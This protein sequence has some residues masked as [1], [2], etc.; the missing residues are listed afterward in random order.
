MLI[1]K[2]IAFIALAAAIAF[3]AAALAGPAAGSPLDNLYMIREGRP[4]RAS[5]SD[6]AWETGNND[7]R[8]LPANTDITIANLEGPG[9]ITH[10]WTTMAC[11]D[12]QCPRL[13]AIRAYWDGEEQPSV[14]APLGDFFAVGHGM[15]VA[16]NSMPVQVSSDGRARNSFW[17]MPFKKSAKI[18]ISNENLYSSG[19]VIYWYVDWVKLDKLP[20]NAAYFHAQYRQEFPAR[21][22]RYKLME[23][24]G[25]GQYVGTVYSV[26]ANMPGWIGEGDDFFY[27]D[28]EKTPS[29]RGTGTEDYFGDAWGF[30]WFNQP[31]H[32]VSVYEGERT[33]GRTTA[34]RWHIADPI[35]F[36]KSIK[37]EIEHVG[38]VFD[39]NDV[40]VAGYGERPDHYATVAFWYQ[41][42]GGPNFERMPK[43]TK[44]LPP[45]IYVEAE[46]RFYKEGAPMPK[47]VKIVSDMAWSGGAYVN[48]SPG[49]GAARFEIPIKIKHKNRYEMSADLARG[50]NMGVYSV[51]LDGKP[52]VMLSDLSDKNVGRMSVDWGLID[53]AEGDHKLVFSLIGAGPNGGSDVGVDGIYMR[54]VRFFADD[55]TQ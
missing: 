39:E 6:P 11:R 52:L 27:L 34:Y 41:N 23:A 28:G 29:L 7:W 2:Q 14:E 48:F 26:L 35:P 55:T 31:Y 16:V 20:E 36:T 32:G 18:V 17:P 42:G 3:N 47:G 45:H 4:M 13:L 5:S 15:D 43:G 30:R 53:L 10:I 54:P 8:L 51:S 25:S 21:P 1:K 46:K 44:R 40:R 9:I 38:P 24:T 37:A 19:V 12:R 22:G 33:G 50:P 49:G